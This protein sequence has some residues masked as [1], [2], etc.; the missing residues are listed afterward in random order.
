MK[1]QLPSGHRTLVLVMFAFFTWNG[2]SWTQKGLAIDG[3]FAGD[4]F[5]R[6]VSMP[7]INTVA[8]GAPRYDIDTTWQGSDEGQVRIFTWDGQSWNQK[9]LGITGA[10]TLS[11][12][13]STL[14]M[15]NAKTIAI[16]SS[17]R[18]VAKIYSWES[19]SWLQKGP[20]ITGEAIGDG[21]GW[22]VTMP[23]TN[24]LGIGA[25]FNGNGLGSGHV[26]VFTIQSNIGVSERHIG[27]FRVFPNPARETI[28][29]THPNAQF[30][31][32][33]NVILYDVLGNELLS[34]VPGRVG[35]VY[36][37]DVSR[38]SAGVYILKVFQN[39]DTLVTERVV[40]NR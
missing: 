6:S 24:T 30:N 21:F 4:F 14:S 35:N 5:G 23:D 15:P 7:D 39:N 20:T 12:V 18:N 34:Q 38:F 2:T 22:S 8:A 27:S 28:T 11:E 3:E 1:T 19:S 10:N 40:I 37:L 33:T 16:G 31:Q 36:E 9:G 26:R 25:P 32:N 29:I 13:G 17:Q